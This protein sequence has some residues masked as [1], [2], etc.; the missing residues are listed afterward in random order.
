MHGGNVR[1]GQQQPASEYA[2][3]Q[4]RTHGL[5]SI[6]PGFA[7]LTKVDLVGPKRP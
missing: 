2:T 7:T 1:L 4:V 5:P 3:V 6:K